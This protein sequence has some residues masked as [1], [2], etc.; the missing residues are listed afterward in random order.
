MISKDIV[1]IKPENLKEAREV[2]ENYQKEVRMPYYYSGGTEIVTFSRKGILSPDCL[3]DIKNIKELR[4]INI[5]DDFITIGSCVTINE[6]IDSKFSEIFSKSFKG[7]ADHTVRNRITIGGNILGQLPFR[8]TILPLLIFDIKI[9]IYEYGGIKE[10]KIS[11]IFDRSLKINKGDIVTQFIIP[12]K[13]LNSD[14]Y[15]E[16]KVFFTKIDYPIISTLFV[17]IND[18]IK[19][20]LTGALNHPLRDVS[21][22]KILNDRNLKKDEKINEIIKKL[23]PEFKS[24]FR[25]SREYRINLFK[26]ILNDALNHFGG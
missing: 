26:N 13:L 20:A 24:D 21:I 22:E 2:Y 4:E 3:I 18:E 23:S 14:F 12:K 25:A 16:R 7:I 19:M 11:N 10:Y 8:E 1:F 5:N 15:Y 17:K 9:K 6:I